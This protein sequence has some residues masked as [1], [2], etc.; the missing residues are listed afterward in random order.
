MSEKKYLNKGAFMTEI[1]KMV[2]V[3]EG[4]IEQVIKDPAMQQAM[5]KQLEVSLPV[6]EDCVLIQ[7]EYV[8]VCGSDVHYFHDGACG[9][10]KVRE[11]RDIPFMLGT[12]CNLWEVRV[13]QIRKI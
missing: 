4:N 5:R 3:D 7:V 1:G 2:V 10:F 12:E 13:L 8:G 6:A 9:T 11:D